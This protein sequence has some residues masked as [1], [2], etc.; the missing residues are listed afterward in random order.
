MRAYRYTSVRFWGCLPVIAAWIYRILACSSAG[1]VRR[2]TLVRD[3]VIS[4][5]W[6]SIN[7][8]RST[9]VAGILSWMLSRLIVPLLLHAIR[10]FA[11]VAIRKYFLWKNWWMDR[12][13]D[14]VDKFCVDMKKKTEKSLECESWKRQYSEQ[15]CKLEELSNK[16]ARASLMADIAWSDTQMWPKEKFKNLKPAE[17]TTQAPI[18]VPE[19]GPIHLG[20]W[21]RL[22]HRID[23]DVYWSEETIRRYAAAMERNQTSIAQLEERLQVKLREIQK[24]NDQIKEC[25][26][27]ARTAFI[28][29]HW[30]RQREITLASRTVTRFREDWDPTEEDTAAPDT[31]LI[32]TA[33]EADSPGPAAIDAPPSPPPA[34]PTL[35]SFCPPLPRQ[36]P[37]RLPPRPPPPTFSKRG[38]R[39]SSA[40]PGSNW[41]L[42][43]PRGR[44]STRSICGSRKRTG[45]TRS[46]PLPG[47]PIALPP[48]ARGTRRMPPGPGGSARRSA[49]GTR[50][51]ARS[52]HAR[53]QKSHPRPPPRTRLELALRLP[54]PNSAPPPSRPVGQPRPRSS[55]QLRRRAG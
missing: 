36:S 8:L 17:F 23:I 3:Q 35:L 25:E 50:T 39:S 31:A 30:A 51:G 44:G 37:R 6:G 40:V 45:R 4:A 46:A 22:R 7:V 9:T 34:A 21:Y 5:A 18:A 15:K 27:S 32:I 38:E 42:L 55:P 20:I 54:R 19:T 28:Q 29:R 33:A 16:V 2:A 1:A 48:I 10:P 52:P 47:T 53:R 13:G 12:L 14:F 43:T 11:P 41:P 24:I 49:V 26:D